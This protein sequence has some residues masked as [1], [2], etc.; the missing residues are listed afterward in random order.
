MS[1]SVNASPEDD[2]SSAK[3]SSNKFRRAGITGV[4]V[5]V[6]SI[7]ACELP[8]ILAVIGLGGLS[9]ASKWL[10]PPPMVEMIGVVI[11]LVG[12][13]MLIG[14]LGYRVLKKQRGQK[15]IT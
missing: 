3:S 14:L 12:L 5:G 1:E 2:N 9:T 4:V 13:L 8:I 7:L 15:T 6:L 10:S 11:G